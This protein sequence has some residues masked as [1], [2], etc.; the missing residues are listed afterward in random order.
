MWRYKYLKIVRSLDVEIQR[1]N[2]L[3][4]CGGSITN[5]RGSLDVGGLISAPM[6]PP[7]IRWNPVILVDSSGIKFGR[8]AC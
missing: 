2:D 8:K 5:I 7:G 6:I 3:R 1:S 4:I